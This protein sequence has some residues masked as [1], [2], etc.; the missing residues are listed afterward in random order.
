[1]ISKIGDRIRDRIKDK[2]N[3]DKR[4]E[5]NKIEIKERW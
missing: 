3:S 4:G 5:N 1:M 2:D